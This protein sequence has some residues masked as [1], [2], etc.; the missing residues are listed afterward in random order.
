MMGALAVSAQESENALQGTGLGDNW[1][2]ALKA[3]AT[4]PLANHPFFKSARP[5]FG[6]EVGKQLTPIFG[7]GVQGTG[8]VNTTGSRTAFDA[9]DIG[10]LG[11]VNLMNLFAG[12]P[13][14]PRTFELEA[15]AGAGW[16]H[17]YRNGNGDTDSW[18]TRLGMNMNFNLGEARAWTLGIKPALVYDMQGDF[19]RAKSRFNAS[20]ASFEL[21]A[22]LAYHFCGSNG[23]RHF[24]W[25]R[26]YDAWEVEELNA[27]VN[28]LRAQADEQRMQLADADR[29]VTVL[30]QEL[31]HCRR[32]PAPVQ[33]VVQNTRIPETVITFRQGRSTVDASQQPNVERIATYLQKHAGAQVAIKGYASPEGD[34]A[35]NE[36]LA[37]ARAQ[38]VKSILVQKY[39]IDAARITAQGQGIGDMFSEPDWNRVS[40]CTIDDAA[41]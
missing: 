18:S 8:Y 20:H 33:T 31:D 14:A 21:T 27:A 6:L 5:A 11:K 16:L 34:A 9:T 30:Q 13:G 7:L 25:V 26:P 4:T 2:V 41:Q 10:L 24:T 23:S 36:K 29:Q 19:N 40:I 12:Y 15:V 1:S 38:A 39:R 3:G 28:D 32:Q 17:Y 35:L 37:A 22:A